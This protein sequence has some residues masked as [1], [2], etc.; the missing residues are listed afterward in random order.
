M[1]DRRLRFAAEIMKEL[2]SM[3]EIK[4]KLSTLFHFQTNGQIEYMN[5]E[6]K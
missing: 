3:L 4:T 6:L 5:Q 1:P 2:N